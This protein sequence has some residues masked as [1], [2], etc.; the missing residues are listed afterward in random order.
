GGTLASVADL[1][2]SNFLAEHADYLSSR[3]SGMW[4][5]L[6]RN[7]NGKLLWQDN[8]VL[9]FVNWAEGQPSGDRL[10]YCVELSTSSGFWSVISCASQRGFIC[11]RPKS[12][13]LSSYFFCGPNS[14]CLCVFFTDAEKDKPHGHNAIWMLLTL[15]LLILVGMTF[16]VYFLFKIK[17]QD[18]CFLQHRTL[19]YTSPLTGTGDET[20]FLTDKERNEHSIV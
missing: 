14:N 3:T 19:D 12:K 1:V 11:K 10:D 8:T 20:D 17:N 6:Y 18:R 16:M 15:V 4:I 5:G 7:I 9:D 2:E 13:W